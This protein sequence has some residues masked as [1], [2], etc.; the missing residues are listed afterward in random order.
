MYKDSKTGAI[1]VELF[2]KLHWITAKPV[3][4]LIF[5][6]NPIITD[7][8]PPYDKGFDIGPGSCL[9]WSSSKLFLY[10]ANTPPD[11]GTA[12]WITNPDVKAK[13]QFN[14]TGFP[15]NPGDAII[16]DDLVLLAQGG[17]DIT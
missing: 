15:V 6:V 10:A 7:D 14:G 9:V 4:D 12:F 1:Y 17:P 16:A 2:G 8:V 3:L 11:E 13:Y 5:G